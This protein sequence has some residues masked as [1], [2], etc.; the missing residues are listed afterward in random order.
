MDHLHIAIPASSEN[1]KTQHLDAEMAASYLRSRGFRI[2]MSNG[3]AAG[4]SLAR[5]LAPLKDDPPAALYWHIPHRP[6]YRLL[7]RERETLASWSHSLVV[8]GGRFASQHD[9]AMLDALP[10]LFAVIRGELEKPLE[11]LLES[12]RSNGASSPPGGLTLYENGALVRRPLPQPVDPD[13]LAPAAEDLF[14]PVRRTQGQQV[15]FNRGCNSD[16][17]YCGMQTVY[18]EGFPGTHR[19]WRSRRARAIVDEI[20]AYHQRHGVTRFLANAAVFFGYDERGT[21]VVEEVA[22]S[23]LD[24]GLEIELHFVT[25]PQH[26]LRNRHLMPLLVEAGLASVYLGLDSGSDAELERFQVE[27]TR[28]QGLAAL[29]VLHEHR[30]GFEVGFFFYTPW[31]T[32]ADIRRNLEFLRQAAPYFSH[33]DAPYPF[34]LDKQLLHQTLPLQNQMPLVNTLEVEGLLERSDPLEDDPRARF[35]NPEV[36]RFFRLHRE[37]F[38]KHLAPLRKIL[39]KRERVG[40]R[41]ELAVLPVD[42]MA[43]VLR[44]FEKDSSNHQ[45]ISSHV[46]AWL[47]DRVGPEIASA[48]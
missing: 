27:F 35:S 47:K 11:E 22:R 24:R 2:S 32:M 33:L 12:L 17:Q 4:G 43:F 23:I 18:R 38:R 14:H 40:Q 48:V 19:F 42:T 5:H 44:E 7:A 25:H 10:G 45:D 26:L 39:W 9:E 15:L 36:A 20:E 31:S 37:I 6:S 21:R 30:V 34:Y 16:C 1:G 46:A 3:G 28:Q 29:G 13:Q 41:P 8:A